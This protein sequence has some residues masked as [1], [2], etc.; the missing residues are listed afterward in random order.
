M[1]EFVF[2][3][4][5]IPAREFGRLDFDWHP[6]ADQQAAAGDAGQLERVVA[7]QPDRAHAEVAQHQHADPV[8][9]RIGRETQPFVGFDGIVALLLQRVGADLI[10]QTNAAALLIEI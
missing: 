2:L 7:E 5:Q 6:L 9:A 10:D 1:T 3:G 4:L 8:V